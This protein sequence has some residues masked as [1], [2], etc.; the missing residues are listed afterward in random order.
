MQ[1]KSNQMLETTNDLFNA[2]M[3]K[4]FKGALTFADEEAIEPAE[5]PRRETQMTLFS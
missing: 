5:E 1:Q 3:Q 4:A 2:L